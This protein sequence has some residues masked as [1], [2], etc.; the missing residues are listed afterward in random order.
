MSGFFLLFEQWELAEGAA[1][2]AETSLS[3]QLDAYCDG[4]GAAP[5]VRDIAEATRLRAGARELLRALQSHLACER[6]SAPL[7]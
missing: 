6:Q 5:S 1:V 3:H 2:R 7:L 4:C